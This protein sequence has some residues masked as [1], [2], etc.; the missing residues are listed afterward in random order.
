LAAGARA[1]EVRRVTSTSV[2]GAIIE[3]ARR[4]YD[5]LVIGAS[6][7]SAGIGGDVLA[8]VVASAPCHVAV[9]KTANP[10]ATFRH[11]LVPVDGSL[12]SRIAVEFAA[13]YAEITSAE[14]T[15]AL[16]AEHRPQAAAWSDEEGSGTD[17]S[18]QPVSDEELARVSLVFRAVEKKPKILHLDYDPSSSALAAQVA[19]GQYDLVV[20]GAE[21][22]AV[23]NRL[24]FGYEN[25]RL[26]RDSDVSIAVV[27]PH[28]GR[29]A[30]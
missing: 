25:E 2:A 10:D 29:L 14:L 8:D 1:P 5:L 23:Q 19:T 22:R 30:R 18:V 21:N 3:E 11:L 4:S 7:R 17:E 27:V 6:A 15:L 9:M 16:L 13:R 28:V 26:I 12:V 24:F 20:I